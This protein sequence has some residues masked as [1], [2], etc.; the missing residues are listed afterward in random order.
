MIRFILHSIIVVLLTVLSQVGGM[1]YL[2]SIIAIKSKKKNHRLKR[3]TLFFTLYLLS[4]FLIVPWIAPYFGRQKIQDN[5]K[6]KAQFVFTKLLNRNYV[7]EE[8]H[9]SLIAIADQFHRKHPQI[10]LIYLDANFPFF[11]GFPLLPHLSHNDGKKIDISFIYKDENGEI[12]NEKPSNSGY[13]IFVAPKA[14]ETNQTEACQAMGAWQYDFPKYLTFG[15]QDELEVDALTTKDLIRFILNHSEV[16][17]IFL[18]PHLKKR[19]NLNASKIR[20]QGC[21]SVRHDDHIHI[22]IN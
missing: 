10:Q 21:H 3:V 1:I 12:T 4:T 2:I 5:D 17:K 6:I 7:T 9:E 18:E 19:W 15:S 20:F 14:N 11:D 13:G 22:Q 16:E 8:L